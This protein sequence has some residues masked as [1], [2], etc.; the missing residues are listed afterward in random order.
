[1]RIKIYLDAHPDLKREDFNKSL[2]FKKIAVQS[3]GKS[4]YTV[5]INRP[6][7]EE[8]CR[9]WAHPNDKLIGVEVFKA[10]RKKFGEEGSKGFIDLHKNAFKSGNEIGGYYRFLDDRDKYMVIVPIEG[11]DLFLP[12]TTYMD[13]FTQPMTD[14]KVK[15]NNITWKNMRTVI[16][17]QVAIIFFVALIAFLYGNN[18]SGKI[19]YLTEVTEHISFGELGK[20]ISLNSNDEI[21]ALANAIGRM[22]D[23][24]RIS[25][26][27]LRR[28]KS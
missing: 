7:N 24:I 22:Q 3:V 1:M 8:P 9:I 6:T 15:A 14:L 13:E 16:I 20:E 19:R 18:L 17:I 5:I 10:M 27:R 23:S 2:E 26:E 4:G 25:I 12:S 21:G 28:R 11:T